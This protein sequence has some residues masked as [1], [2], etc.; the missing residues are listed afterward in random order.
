MDANCDGCISWD[1]FEKFIMS[2][3]AAGQRLLSGEFV[4]PSGERGHGK[5]FAGMAQHRCAQRAMARSRHHL[6]EMAV[7]A[8]CARPARQGSCDC[9]LPTV[10]TLPRAC[11]R[12]SAG[13][14]LP[15]GA[16]VRQLKR[17]Q[18]VKD[19]T[20]VCVSQRSSVLNTAAAS[21]WGHQA[22]R[23][24]GRIDE[25]RWYASTRPQ[26]RQVLTAA[27][28][29]ACRAARRAPSGSTSTST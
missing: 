12:V 13:T 26:Q 15:F 2:E 9:V 18:M 7:A 14:A 8:A 19:V 27:C 22:L 20:E 21:D 23:G 28:K 24:S 10:D 29:P 5:G 11:A 4:L 6:H 3:F 25:P 17:N 1:E 16:M